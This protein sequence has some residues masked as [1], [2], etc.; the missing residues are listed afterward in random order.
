MFIP[1]RMKNLSGFF[2][3]FVISLGVLKSMG[4]RDDIIS[5]FRRGEKML[6]RATIFFRT[7]SVMTALT[8]HYVIAN[9]VKQSNFEI[10][11]GKALAMTSWYIKF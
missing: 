4:A 8:K 2:L 3:E 5:I 7:Q 9:V 10:A 1:D 11:S 6:Y